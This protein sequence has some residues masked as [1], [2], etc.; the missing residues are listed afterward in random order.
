ML[1]NAIEYGINSVAN[2]ILV[3]IYLKERILG[4]AEVIPNKTIYPMPILW[5]G[6]SYLWE[7][8]ALRLPNFSTSFSNRYQQLKSVLAKHNVFSQ[9]FLNGMIDFRLLYELLSNKANIEDLKKILQNKNIRLD[10]NTFNMVVSSQRTN[11]RSSYLPSYLGCLYTGD[12]ELKS[13]RRMKWLQSKLQ[14]DNWH[15]HI[16]Q[17]PHHGAK[18]NNHNISLYDQY[19][20]CVISAHSNDNKHPNSDVIEDIITGNCIPKIITEDN[21]TCLRLTYSPL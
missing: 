6:N 3:Q 18:G 20:L 17:V 14:L 4:D 19:Q 8:K 2:Q 13:T 7:Y 21:R 11:L 16:I 5:N 10:N 1:Y 9:V 15:Y 12:A